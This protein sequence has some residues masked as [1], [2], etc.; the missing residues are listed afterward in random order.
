MMKPF[1]ALA[2]CVTWRDAALAIAAGFLAF[3][4]Y[5]AWAESAYVDQE[6][7]E[8]AMEGQ[9]EDIKEIKEILTSCLLRKECE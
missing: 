1:E 8:T 6:V 7:Y 2:Q 5:V 4:G 9:A 3:G